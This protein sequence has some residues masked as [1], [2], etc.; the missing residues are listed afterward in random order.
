MKYLLMYN[1]VS[2]RSTIKWKLPDIVQMFKEN[3]KK[4]DIY[5]STKKNDLER[6]AYEMA[7]HY[8]VFLV[9]GGDGTINEVVN[10]VMKS[11]KRPKIGILPC[12]TANDIASILRIPKNFKKALKMYFEHDAELIDINQ[13]NQRY[14][15][16]AAASGVLSKISYDIKRKSLNRYGYL[17]YVFEGMKDLAKD[18]KYNVEIEHD[19]GTLK[20]E[21]MMVMGLSSNRVG[22]LRLKNF[23]NSKVNDGL[24]ELRIFKRRRTFRRFRFLSSFIRGG[25]KLREDFHI[26]STCFKI[27]TNEDV[28]WNT[29]GEQ[30]MCGNIEIKVHPKAIAFYMNP[31]I[32]KKLL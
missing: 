5:E 11:D 28:M 22:G 17:A 13:M 4:V 2:G 18:Y 23:A 12:G 10:G 6:H 8:D 32:K 27:K 26:A 30:A 3:H 14:F 20:T 25:K 24:F 16:Y 21:C 15:V 31:K 9:C 7:P 29:D 19:Q 1:P